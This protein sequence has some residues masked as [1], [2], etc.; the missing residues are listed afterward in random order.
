[1]D[2]YQGFCNKEP[3]ATV[4]A[5]ENRAFQYHC[6]NHPPPVTTWHFRA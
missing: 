3:I 1:M 5:E 6:S 4:A 2:A